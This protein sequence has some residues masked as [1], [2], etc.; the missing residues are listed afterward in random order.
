M[1]RGDGPVLQAALARLYR[2]RPRRYDRSGSNLEGGGMDA[3]GN[4]ERPAEDKGQA[5]GP[6]ERPAKGRGPV[7]MS[8][9]FTRTQALMGLVALGIFYWGAVGTLVGYR[10]DQSGS[11]GGCRARC[12]EVAPE[13]P[14][15]RVPDRDRFYF[16]RGWPDHHVV[17]P[18]PAWAPHGQ[19]RVLGLYFEPD[20]HIVGL[21]R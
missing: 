12:L 21:R 15:E 13:P 11:Q 18:G 5:G 4:D 7:F 3:M 1:R 8:V 16:R 19:P 2:R 20:R 6:A 17:P 14:P 10:L 9:R